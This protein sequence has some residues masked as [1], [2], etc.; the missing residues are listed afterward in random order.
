MQSLL[1]KFSASL[2]ANFLAHGQAGQFQQEAWKFPL[3]A[4][5]FLCAT[6]ILSYEL[7][8]LPDGENI[9]FRKEKVE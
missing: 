3:L 4:N 7:V 6:Y 5:L 1:C 8:E 9:L 2:Q